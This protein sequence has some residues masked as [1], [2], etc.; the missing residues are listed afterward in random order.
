MDNKIGAWLEMMHNKKKNSALNLNVAFFLLLISCRMAC[1]ISGSPGPAVPNLYEY[2][3]E[4][5]LKKM[6][7]VDGLDNEFTWLRKY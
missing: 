3:I 5:I 2:L 6:G 7:M 1:V 4:N